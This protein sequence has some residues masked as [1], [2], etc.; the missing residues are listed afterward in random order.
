MPQTSALK[1]RRE[2]RCTM[3]RS[4]ANTPKRG[5]RC[6]RWGI[7]I[8]RNPPRARATRRSEGS[9]PG[10]LLLAQL[11]VEDVDILLEMSARPRLRREAATRV[12][13]VPEAD[14]PPR[15]RASADVKQSNTV[16]GVHWVP[17][18][19]GRHVERGWVACLGR[20]GPG[21]PSCRTSCRYRRTRPWRCP[22]APCAVATTPAPARRACGSPLGSPPHRPEARSSCQAMPTGAQ[23]T[24]V[25]NYTGPLLHRGALWDD[26]TVRRF[27]NAGPSGPLRHLANPTPYGSWLTVGTVPCIERIGRIDAK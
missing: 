22:R 18:S 21:R 25:T 20:R 3:E 15:G 14:L 9:E 27:G 19:R 2:L 11:E 7:R 4:Y 1:G 6:E 5:R 26:G 16:G 8:S 24:G 17:R 10:D 13:D 23:P 12:N